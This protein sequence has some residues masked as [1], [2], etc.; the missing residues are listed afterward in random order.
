MS[1]KCEISLS[2]SFFFF[3]FWKWRTFNLTSIWRCILFLFDFVDTP[4]YEEDSKL[5]SSLIHAEKSIS[6]GIFWYS[7]SSL[8]A[9][10]HNFHMSDNWKWHSSSFYGVSRL[11]R[12]SLRVFMWKWKEN[13]ELGENKIKEKQ[14]KWATSRKGRTSK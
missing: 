12:F 5:R 2:I 7:H 4:M 11:L 9:C 1:L 8:S 13:V 14:L 6:C 10:I 3:F